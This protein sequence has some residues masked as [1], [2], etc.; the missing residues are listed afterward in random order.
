M[1]L[2]SFL[3]LLE[4]EG[5]LIK[6]EDELSPMLEIPYVAAKLDDRPILFE[7]VEGFPNSSVCCNVCSRRSLVAKALGVPERD[8]HDRISRAME[9]PVPPSEA[10]FDFPVKEEEINLPVLKHFE[11]DA[12]LYITAGIVT[13][14]Y[15][16][17]ENV[18]IHRLLVLDGKHLAIRLTERHLHKLWTEAKR[19]GKL[20]DV[21]IAI[22]V[23]PAVL[24]AA[25]CPVPF[26]VSEYGV[27]NSLLGGEMRLARCPITELR[28][29][30]DAEVVIEGRFSDEWAEEGPCGD[31]L[32]LYDK[33]RK[34]PVIEVMAVYRKDPYIYQGLLPGFGDHMTLA[35][36]PVEASLKRALS[37][38]IPV[39]DVRLTPGSGGWLHAVVSVEEPPSDLESLAKRAFEVHR[40]LKGI[41]VVDA[42][43]D[44]DD[45]RDIEWALA[46]RFQPDKDFLVLE[47]MRGSSLDPS[48]EDGV[49]SKWIADATRPREK[50]AR[51]FE[52]I[53]PKGT[54]R[55]EKVLKKIV[56]HA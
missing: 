55:A 34:Q 9:N 5:L 30:S 41:I 32:R 27:A 39:K 16:G 23:H 54:E 38:E 13:A 25:V 19:E 10:S 53:L 17:V 42:D 52:R 18:S 8:L 28:V 51:L 24:V 26:G 35:S 50:P 15:G 22:S 4:D 56:P 49:T 47:G 6:I 45:V 2:R 3:N 29:P 21:A 43:I 36:L 40:S 7:K 33:T 46:T 37:D 12:G 14:S 1:S 31:A 11:K 48:S 44:V 20:L